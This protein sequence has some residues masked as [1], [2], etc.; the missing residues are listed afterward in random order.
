MSKETRAAIWEYLTLAYGFI[1]LILLSVF[2][3]I[4]YLLNVLIRGLQY[5]RFVYF[6]LLRATFKLIRP[7]KNDKMKWN[8]AMWDINGDGAE[9]GLRIVTLG[10]DMVEKIEEEA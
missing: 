5:L 7:S 10:F 4:G 8:N 9:D 3:L 6:K 1:M 2:G